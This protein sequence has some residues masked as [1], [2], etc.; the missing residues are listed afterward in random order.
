MSYEWGPS[1]ITLPIRI[2]GIDTRV[3]KNL[4]YALYNIRH[5]KEEVVLWIDAICINQQDLAEKARLVPQMSTVYQ[6]AEEVIVWLGQVTPPDVVRTYLPQIA[7]WQTPL[8][9]ISSSYHTEW[10][11]QAVPWLYQLIIAQYWQRTWIIQEIGEAV[12]LTVH[13]GDSSLPW[14]AFIS[15]VHVFRSCFSYVE[16]TDM[17]DLMNNL[18]VSKR[19]GDI[20]SLADLVWQFRDSFCKMPQDKLYAFLGMADDDPTSTFIAAYDRSLRDVYSDFIQYLARS[21]VDTVT[22]EIQV[23][24]RSAIMRYL[25]VRR[26]GKVKNINGK[27]C[28][29]HKKDDP[30]TYQYTVKDSEGKETLKTGVDFRKKWSEWE[31][32][33]S[34]HEVSCWLSSAPEQL[35]TWTQNH[36]L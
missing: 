7:K 15:L 1:D 13:F 19:N 34:E 33:T 35:E 30:Y 10:W 31:E 18:R 36:S 24:Q 23:I 8:S 22:K 3:R 2:N 28:I 5:P 17:V 11:E 32:C 21:A 29:V 4:W 12:R 16:K 26:A 20:Y 25:L 14:D 9:K 27:P 6:R